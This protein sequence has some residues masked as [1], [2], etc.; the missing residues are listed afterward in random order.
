MKIKHNKNFDKLIDN[1]LFSTIR[2]KKREYEEKYPDAKIVNLGVG[3]VVGGLA[4]SVIQA[5]EKAIKEYSSPETFK[6]YPPE[7]GYDFLRSKIADYYATSNV[8]ISPAEIYISDG[9]K[10]DIGNILDIFGKSTAL[11]P[12]P[13]YPAYLDANVMHGNKIKFIH[14]TKGNSFLPLPDFS[15]KKSYLIF[16]CSPNNPTGAVYN[17][18]Q[19]KSWVNYANGNGSIIIFDSA[20]E[21][22]IKG[23]YP[24][25]IFEIEGSRYC[26][27]E[28]S[29]FSK[30]AGFTGLRLGYSIIPSE[31][32]LSNKKAGEMWLRRQSAKFNGVSYVIQ[33]GGEASLS[34]Q[35]IKECSEQ[36][37]Y[38]LENANVIKNVFSEIG[39]SVFGGVNAPYVW[40]DCKQNSWSFF[41]R[42]LNEYQIVGSAG[43]G[44]GSEGENF[45]RL[46]AFALRN[47]V[48]TARKRLTKG[49]L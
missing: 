6:G 14:G 47:D 7:Q 17:R 5:M 18:E 27:I 34:E 9:A 37:A 2:A 32:V 28:I 19:L 11:I 15:D 42:L 41:D 29:S 40:I 8:K 25:S 45:F 16:L 21:S 33:K 46:S 26:S 13:V 23:D 38:Y 20:Y 30:R 31:L 10:S 3:D 1:Y 36:V 43:S 35:G 4:P 39:F 24:K 12:N 49:R 44:F 22:F 48:E